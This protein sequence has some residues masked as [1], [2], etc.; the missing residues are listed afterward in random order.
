[1]TLLFAELAGLEPGARVFDIRVQNTIVAENVDIA[2]QAGGPLKALAKAFS[3]IAASKTMLIELL[4]K[5]GRPLLCG[6][7][8]EEE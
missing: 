5:T 7:A 4:P 2:G 3:G 1:M 6:L 8:L